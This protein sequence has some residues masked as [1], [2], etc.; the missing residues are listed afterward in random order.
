MKVSNPERNKFFYSDVFAT[1]EPHTK[2]SE[3]IQHAPELT[4]QVVSPPIRIAD[5]V[6]KYI[7]YSVLD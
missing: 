2:E 7:A 1:K 6:D 3:Y 5:S 4:A